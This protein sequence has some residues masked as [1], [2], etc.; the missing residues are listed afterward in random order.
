MFKSHS[1]TWKT[2]EYLA[3]LY[4]F[5]LKGKAG[6]FKFGPVRWQ[7]GAFYILLLLASFC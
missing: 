6:R 5:V 4:Y 3:I 7:S 2:M 1:A